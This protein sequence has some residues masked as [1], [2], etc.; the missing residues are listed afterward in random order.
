M[1]VSHILMPSHWGREVIHKHI[2]QEG[3]K[4][5]AIIF[6][7]KNYSAERPLLEYAAKAAREHEC[8]LLLLEYGYQSARADFR[9]EEMEIVVEECK[10][11]IASLPEYEK[12][13]MIGKSM[14]TLIAGRVAQELGL[15]QLSSF[16][17]LTPL[18]EAIPLIRQSR[19]TVI[20]GSSDPLF[21]EQHAAEIGG[22]P[23]LQVY[24]ID[25]ANHSLE[26]GAVSESLAVLLVIVNFY[27]SFLRD[28]LQGS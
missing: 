19:G 20:Y 13:L 16:L 12:T 24:R 2:K 1:S 4:A 11:A 8:D 28:A 27:H 26:V 10:A 6:P 17:Y 21:S 9:R 7:G 5:L 23:G 22:V 3:A 25:D 15:Q 18:P 14:G